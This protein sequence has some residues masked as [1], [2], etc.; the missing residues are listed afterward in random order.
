[1]S[2]SELIRQALK[3]SRARG[4]L[5]LV[6]VFSSVNLFL[7][8]T[9]STISFPFSAVIPIVAFVI[10]NAFGGMAAAFAL[11]FLCIAS[12]LFCWEFSKKFRVLMLVAL[13]FYVVDSAVYGFIFLSEFDSS[14]FIQLAFRAWVLYYLV[15]GT[16]AWFNLR[17][18]THDQISAAENEAADSAAK[19][20]TENALKEILPEEEKNEDEN[21]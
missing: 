14:F 16:T 7:A 9:D 17:G 4:N 18:T 3:F 1:M 21:N 15:T 2:N 19:I 6:I 10:G 8:A 13:I 11:A 20:E 12:Y 5:L